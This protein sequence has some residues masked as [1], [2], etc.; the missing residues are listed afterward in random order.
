MAI[1]VPCPRCQHVTVMPDSAGGAIGRCKRCGAIVRVPLAAHQR[2]FCCVC[3]ADV[4][5]GKRVKDRDGAYYCPTCWQ[6]R[7]DAETASGDDFWSAL[8]DLDKK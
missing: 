2:K 5:Q 3:H 4:S 1:Q 8:E 7:K 6:A